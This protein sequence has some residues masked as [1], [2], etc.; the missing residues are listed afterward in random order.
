MSWRAPAWLVKPEWRDRAAALRSFDAGIAAT[1]SEVAKRRRLLRLINAHGLSVF[2]ESGTYLG[3]TAEFLAPHVK[4][5]VTIEIDERLCGI[6]AERLSGLA[7]VEVICG[8]ASEHIPRLVNE[9]PE[10]SLIWLDGHFSGEGTGQ[11]DEVE[12]AA[13][14]IEL[15]SRRNLTPGT[16]ILIDDLRLFGVNPGWPSLARV[17]DAAESFQPGAVVSAE[18]DA[19]TIRVTG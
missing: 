3:G 19:L 18:F 14:I 15:L 16:T 7:N 11:G 9:L 13:N 12:P 5:V 10:P 2:L 17:I 6:A 4:R 8:D 1:P